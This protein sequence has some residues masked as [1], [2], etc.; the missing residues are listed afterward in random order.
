MVWY[1][2]FG[3]I[4][5][6]FFIGLAFLLTST[7]INLLSSAPLSCISMNNQ[8]CKVRPQIVNVNSE[9]TV[10][11]PFSIK[12]TKLNG[13]CN[14]INNLYTK[15][16]VFDGVKNVNIKVFNAMW[17]TNETRHIECHERCKC[18]CRLND[19]VCNNKQ[20]W[21]K[22]KSRCECK[23]LIDK[24]VCDKV[25]IWNPTNWECEC[26]KSCDVG[27]YLEYKNCKCRKKLDDK[28]IEEC[29][30]NVEEVKLAK[31][32]STENKNKHKCSSCT[33]YI[34]LFS[35]IFTI[36]VGIGTYFVYYKYMNC[37]KKT[38]AKEQ[39]YFWGKNY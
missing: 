28:L 36:N 34:V 5:W 16:C 29:T 22:G 4:K 8:E 33:L 21:N 7:R 24:G 23:E 6:C 35:I 26:D 10:F 9:K 18:H 15:L 12:T 13:S 38:G 39:F 2:M 19:S 20:R 17:R 3:F 14:N 37:D 27:E 25:F 31:I 30:E 32:T 11:F 1:K